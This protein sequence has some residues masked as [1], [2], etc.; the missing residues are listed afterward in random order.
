MNPIKRSSG[1]HN[2]SEMERVAEVDALWR[3][4]E[5]QSDM[6][7]GLQ[8]EINECKTHIAVLNLKASVWT[9]IGAFIATAMWFVKEIFT[10]GLK[11]R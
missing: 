7:G 5:K 9:I 1:N 11:G 2:V 6:I 4:L 3:A 10:G 8:R